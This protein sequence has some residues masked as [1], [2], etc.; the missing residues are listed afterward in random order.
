MAFRRW[1]RTRGP[2]LEWSFP[3]PAPWRSM[4]AWVEIAA[5]CSRKAR[6]HCADP[7]GE[8]PR[9]GPGEGGEGGRLWTRVRQ[10]VLD[11]ATP[12]SILAPCRGTDG[13][14]NH[15]PACRSSR[16]TWRQSNGRTARDA[17]VT[18]T[19]IAPRRRRRLMPRGPPNDVMGL[20]LVSPERRS[21]A[22]TGGEI[23]PAR[24]FKPAYSLPGNLYTMAQDKFTVASS[25]SRSDDVA[26]NV[27][28]AP[29]RFATRSWRNHLLQSLH[30]PYVA[31]PAGRSLRMPSAPGPPSRN[32]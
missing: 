20:S 11:D 7:S 3:H 30:A 16:D 17:L 5:H 22:G 15:R 2:R 21:L 25:R 27:A 31:R 32:A 8:T 10:C 1:S 4:R 9:H 23:P 13:R 29:A 24:I 18:P 6:D 26:S 14:T 19:V 28:R 12:R